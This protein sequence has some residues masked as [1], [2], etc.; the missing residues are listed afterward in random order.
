VNTVE[1]RV[2][3]NGSTASTLPRL[4]TLREAATLLRCGQSTL[5]A[6]ARRREIGHL[7]EGRRLLFSDADLATYIAARRVEAKQ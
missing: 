6:A 2:T 3:V 5:R 1:Q 7:R 4:H